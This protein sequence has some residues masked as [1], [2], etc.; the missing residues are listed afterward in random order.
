[1]TVETLK[2][3]YIQEIRDLYDAEKQIA[4]ALPKMIDAASF[5]ELRTAFQDHLTQTRNQVE[6]LERVFDKLGEK[7]KG[8]K[9]DGIRGILDEGEEMIDLDTG[10]SVHDAA[11]ISAAQRVEHYEIAA[12][13]TVC[14][15]AKSLGFDDQLSLLLETLNEEKRTDE[16]L[17]RIAE[18]VVNVEAVRRAG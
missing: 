14:A 8:K 9:C 4:K 7:A 12:Y 18:N 11:L 1:M 16:L 15:Y 3:L 5:E 13:G 6:R 2:D 17:T 10:A